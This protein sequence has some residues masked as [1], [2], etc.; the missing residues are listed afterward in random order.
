[1]NG[2]TPA[3]AQKRRSAAVSRQLE[4]REPGQSLLPELELLSCFGAL[5]PL[6]LPCGVIGIL[7]REV[8]QRRRRTAGCIAVKFHQLADENGHRPTVGDDV[9]HREHDELI[10]CRDLQQRYPEQ[11]TVL[12]IERGRYHFG[13]PLARVLL[14]DDLFDQA[15]C[16]RCRDDNLRGQPVTFNERGTKRFVASHERIERSLEKAEVERAA[17]SNHPGDDI[18]GAGGIEPREKPQPL[19]LR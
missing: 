16:P 3:P 5:S 13:G 1:M 17:G 10:A 6:M 15:R 12:E 11:R 9:V 8:G 18:R 7:Q 2:V 19:L 14:G 4:L